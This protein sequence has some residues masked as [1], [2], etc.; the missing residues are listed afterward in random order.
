MALSDRVFCIDF[1]AAYTKVALRRA[2]GKPSELV[3]YSR[4]QVVF[5]GLN[6]VVPTVVV[7]DQRAGEAKYVC[8][9][10]AAER[11]PEPKIEVHRNWK[12]K[13]FTEPLT[14]SAKAVPAGF[15][16]ADPLVNLLWSPR[17]QSLAT[18][19]GVPA[20]RVKALHGLVAA[21]FSVP[22]SGPATPA[23]TNPVVWV[24]VEFFRHL[25]DLVLKACD[26]LRV[27][28]ADVIPAR[29]ALPALAD[30]REGGNATR[31]E[32]VV[33]ILK[34]AGWTVHPDRGV[35]SEPYANAVG[36]LTRG[37]NVVQPTGRIHFG[38]MFHGGPL[39]TA[40]G[41]PEYHPEYRALVLDIGAFTTDFAA[42][43]VR[44]GGRKV[45]DPDEAIG[46]SVLSVPHGVS[47]LDADV[48]AAL[49]GEKAD[50]LRTAATANDWETFRQNVYTGT[51]GLMTPSVGNIGGAKKEKEAIK[52]VIAAFTGKVRREAAA[53][54]GG[55]DAIDFQELILT[56]G[57][58]HIPDVREGLI[59]AAQGEGGV[60]RKVHLPGKPRSTKKDGV[61]VPLS[62]ELVRGATALGG[63]SLY[64]E[65]AFYG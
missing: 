43:T 59:D 6:F 37:A 9:V 56:G 10:A 63:A 8:G 23:T 58:C 26:R 64:F 22:P 62:D 28:D 27:P 41:Q 18:E 42:L 1:G 57:G 44:T 40:I 3:D 60:F 49:P 38:Q 36:V 7:C 19:M 39:V 51:K 33:R 53:F 50:W 35:L 13:L 54:T 5:D 34:R 21:A 32:A 14:S 31:T 11:R 4:E 29:V 46:V 47:T 20:D 52:E 45:A 24:A 12:A 25:R 30:G 61:V 65:H 15:T 17:F 2:P 55:L 16:K 48:L